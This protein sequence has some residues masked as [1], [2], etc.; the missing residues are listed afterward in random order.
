MFGRIFNFLILSFCDYDVLHPARWAGV[1]N[2]V[3]LGTL[4]RAFV[5]KSIYNALAGA[6]KYTGN[7]YDYFQQLNGR[8][9]GKENFFSD[10]GGFSLSC[11]TANGPMGMALIPFFTVM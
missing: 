11:C 4:D 6:Q 1:A 7:H 3:A 10:I 2:Y 5:M 8:R 9:G